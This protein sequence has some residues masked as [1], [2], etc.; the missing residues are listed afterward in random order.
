MI[1]WEDTEKLRALIR[2]VQSSA[3]TSFYKDRLNSITADSFQGI[4]DLPLLE[5]K[6]L[7]Q[8]HPSD[9]CFVE[10]GEVDFVAYTSGT[11][12]GE[13]LLTYLAEVDNY[14][15]DPSWGID[16]SRLLVVF[17]PL[18]K[19]FGGTFI[20]QCRQAPESLMPVFGDITNM[21]TS[22]YLGG[23]VG[24]D[25]LY[26]TPSLALEL[27]PYLKKY[28]SV[29]AIT[30]LAISGETIG[31]TKLATLQA[32]YPN[33]HIA[34]LYA[35]SEIGQFIMGPTKKMIL[36]DVKGFRILSEAVVAA[37][38]VEGELVI[39]YA[40]NKA[41]PLIRYRTGD[42]FEVSE[43]LTEKYGEGLPILTWTGKGGVDVVR[44][45]GVEVRTGTVDTFF[46]SLPQS[47][48]TY[49]LHVLPGEKDGTLSLRLEYVMQNGSGIISELIRE[50]FMEDFKLSQ[51]VSVADAVSQGFVEL[52]VVQSV[53]EVSYVSNKR[54]VLVN[55][56]V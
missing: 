1:L 28:H 37:E 22:A 11:T 31:E 32:L 9:R 47:I 10:E 54:R 14:F 43:S 29:E 7:T 18:N 42:H 52:V 26:A 30:L 2:T 23:S 12:G 33:A 16:V 55:N 35:S 48:D 17:P 40:L 19:N 5:R 20:Q 8:T 15:I 3:Y 34:N 25:A 41:F 38:L 44:V 53:D 13:P 46:D 56:I 21:A 6:D 27:A 45:H 4:E 49:Q 39:T 24:C 50:R 51:S 36:D